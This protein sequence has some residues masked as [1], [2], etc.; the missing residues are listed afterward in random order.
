MANL[1]DMIN[2]PMK[3]YKF[4][5]DRIKGVR[6]KY[7][8]SENRIE[9]KINESWFGT[10]YNLSSFV[11]DDLEEVLDYDKT[12]ID[13]LNNEGKIYKRE[14]CDSYYKYVDNSL[15]YKLDGGDWEIRD[16][17]INYLLTLK[18]AEYNGEV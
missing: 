18:F 10:D 11:E 8:P 4:K 6:Y 13:I 2:N 5:D 17:D 1:I 3:E 15:L 16:A 14:E 12:I 7:N 9:Y